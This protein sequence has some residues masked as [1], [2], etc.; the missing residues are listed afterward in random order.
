MP[1]LLAVLALLTALCSASTAGQRYS[2]GHIAMEDGVRLWHRSV[3]EGTEAVVV[4]VLVLT[5]PHFDALAK[6]EAVRQAIWFGD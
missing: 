2:Q 5:S 6:G 4:P 1:V 3:G